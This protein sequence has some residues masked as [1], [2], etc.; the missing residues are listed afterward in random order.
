M[1]N[2]C[3]VSIEG[4]EGGLL[5]LISDMALE[6]V[7]KLNSGIVNLLPPLDS[8]I[9]GY[10]ERE[11]FLSPPHYNNVFD[12][13]GNAAPTILLDGKV[14]GVWSFTADKKPVVKFLFFEQV[15]NSVLTEVYSKAQKIG[16]FISDK[17][18][19]VTE[20]SS[21][22]PLTRRTAGEFMSPLKNC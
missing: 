5:L 6:N 16:E 18:V 12:R 10:K 11:R 20:C 21:M 8:Y 2:N 22:H 13:S 7:P 19:T 17:E 1:E 14:V 9:I 3:S 4:L 15:E